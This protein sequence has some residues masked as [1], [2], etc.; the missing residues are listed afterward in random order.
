YDARDERAVAARLSR[1][2]DE[3]DERDTEGAP[4][5]DDEGA[6]E[7]A[8][9]DDLVELDGGERRDDEEHTP[10]EAEDE[11]EE[12]EEE[13][14]AENDDEEEDDDEDELAEEDA[15]PREISPVT[16]TLLDELARIEGPQGGLKHAI[17][18]LG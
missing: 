18:T 9:G 7:L 3:E 5:E 17:A 6:G 16:P 11:E 12:E 13:V 1:A 14:A 4:V 10:V 2:F 15:A 8:S